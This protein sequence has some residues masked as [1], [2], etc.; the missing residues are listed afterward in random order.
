MSRKN[1]GKPA[2]F[3]M[4]LDVKPCSKC[5]TPKPLEDFHR[6]TKASDGRAS[7]CK[8]CA[9]AIYRRERKRVYSEEKK[10][11][12]HLKTR[13]G[14]TPEDFERM[15]ANQNG[16]CALCPASPERLR[17]DHCH[18]TGKVRGLLCHQC[19]IRLGGWDDLSWRGKPADQCPDGPRYKALGNSMAVP[20]MR[21]VGERLVKELTALSTSNTL[22][23]H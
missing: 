22:H 15:L 11:K 21:W 6:Q 17:V 3:F 16:S 9:N 20:V 23:V 12:W 7:W 1:T 4:T 14:I 18:A 10:R 5:K 8:T 19:N 13:Y 2:R